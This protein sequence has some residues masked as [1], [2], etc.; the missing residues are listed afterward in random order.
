M[1]KD[2]LSLLPDAPGCYLYKDKRGKIIYV[3]KA[4]NLKNRVKSYFTGSHNLKTTKLVLEIDDFDFI[5]TRTEL[6]SLV[7]EINLIKQHDPK[8]NIKLTDDKTY[9]YIQITS[10]AHPRLRV[11]RNVSQ[12]GSKLFGP[13]PNVFSAR[14]TARLLNKIYPLRKCDTLPKQACLYY[15]MGQCL[16][17]CI[18]KEPID[19][20]PMIQ[21]ITQFLKGD[22]KRVMEDL[23]TKMIEASD[24]LEFERA[25]EY[26][27]MI[28]HI[29]TTTE[30]QTMAIHDLVDRDI[31][32]Y[33][34]NDNE[35]AV[36]IFFM[37][38]GKLIANAVKVFS[39][40]SD[41]EDAVISYI[42]Q[43]YQSENLIPKEVFIQE[44]RHIALLEEVLRTKVIHPK[45]GDKKKLLDLAI[46]NARVDLE[47]HAM[48]HRMESEKQNTALEELKSLLQ[49]NHVDH[50]EI[51][52]NSN[53]MGTQAVSAMVVYKNGKPSKKDYRKYSIKT[54]DGIDDTKTMKE[55]IYRRYYRLMMENQTLPDLIVVD[56]GK[57]QYHAA[58]DVLMSLGLEIPLIGLKKDTRHKT[59]AVVYQEQLHALDKRSVLYRFL[60]SMQD[61]VHRFAIAFHHNRRTKAMFSSQL[62]GIPG[63]GKAR[64]EVLLKHFQSIESIK[65]AALSDFTAIGISE[66]L[67]KK[68]LEHLKI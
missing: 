50:I 21:E 61:E 44:E 25:K 68:I 30:K 39:F 10:E 8:Y 26:R 13:Y 43:F 3:G 55:V 51:F 40:I 63:I 4:K 45:V 2:K 41:P 52:D 1:I 46:E 28:K 38:Q 37:R 54:V 29:E 19:Y 33:V 59:E 17:P 53:I 60:A 56:G 65:N 49:V 22:T 32:G 23:K 47:N 48:L 67:A 7:L 42:A 20:K 58:Q 18:F 11:V 5:V 34:F 27:D 24:A 62:D 14:E 31:I 64:K 57:G 12:K 9:P 6:E 35:M 16:A 66:T 15:H 36:N